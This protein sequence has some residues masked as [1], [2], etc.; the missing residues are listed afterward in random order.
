MNNKKIKIKK[1]K[2]GRWYVPVTQLFREA[3]IGRWWSRWPGHKARP[4]L[5][6][7]QCAKGLEV[8]L[9]A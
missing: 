5:K 4:R 6:N 9:S 3:Q 8:W 7:N 1:K 2:P